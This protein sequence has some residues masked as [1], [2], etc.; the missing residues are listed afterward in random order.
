MA[1]PARTIA[2]AAIAATAIFLTS[3]YALSRKDRL[4]AFAACRGSAIVGGAAAIGGP[5][6][7]TDENGRTVTDREVLA[8]PA[9]V[10][11]GYTYCPDVCPVDAARNAAAVD[12]LDE[13]GY[14]VTPVFISVDPQR[15][16]ADWLKEWTD[17]IHPRMVGLTGTKDQ[18]AAAAQAYKTF[19]K[20]PDEPAD[21]DY[22]V[23]HMT[24]TYLMLPN[25]GF[26]EFF[27]RDI[28]ADEVADRTS[29]FLDA[30]DQNG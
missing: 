8:E 28:S 17:L 18:I 25:V 30:T 12:V 29:C 2:T 13:R 16:T 4:D 5:F 24:H 20:A 10:Y 11:F 19:Y 27:S 9:L 7:L 14:D 3:I 22:L 6:T 26:V 1:I 23:D 15:D 21:A